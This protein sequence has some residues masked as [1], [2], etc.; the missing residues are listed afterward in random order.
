MDDGLGMQHDDVVAS[1]RS[2]GAAH[3]PQCCQQFAQYSLVSSALLNRRRYPKAE[4]VIFDREFTV[5]IDDE[6]SGVVLRLDQVDADPAVD[7]QMIDLG[8]IP[9]DHEA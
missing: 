8:N 9:I 5:V 6:I 1:K 4:I 7:D 3:D 2:P